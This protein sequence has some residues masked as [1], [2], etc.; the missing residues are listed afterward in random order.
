MGATSLYFSF[1]AGGKTRY[2]AAGVAI[3]PQLG[4]N[5]P[6]NVRKWANLRARSIH[7]QFIIS[8]L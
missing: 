2:L 3:L 7:K 5:Y 8:A 1:A 4:K 6:E